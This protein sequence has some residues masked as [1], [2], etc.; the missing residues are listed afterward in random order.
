M[1][2]SDRRATMCTAHP[3]H[4]RKTRLR[5]ATPG[6]NRKWQAEGDSDVRDEARVEHRI[7]S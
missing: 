5:Q 7:E 6:H 4:I 1:L 2:A 3:S